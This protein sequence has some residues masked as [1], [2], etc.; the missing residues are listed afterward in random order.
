M[1]QVRTPWFLA[2]AAKAADTV[3]QPKMEMAFPQMKSSFQPTDQER[4]GSLS[5]W[6]SNVILARVQRIDQEVG[7]QS[8]ECTLAAVSR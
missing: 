3:R 2:G 5:D 8:S 4:Y 7:V 1:A 6:A